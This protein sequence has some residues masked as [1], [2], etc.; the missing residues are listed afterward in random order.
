MLTHL[1]NEAN[2]RTLR[3]LSK[4]VEILG[5][6][7]KEIGPNSSVNFDLTITF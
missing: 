4:L 7:T 3:G 1:K 2:R 5:Q 6:Y